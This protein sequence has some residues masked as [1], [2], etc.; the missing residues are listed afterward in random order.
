MLLENAK[1][2]MFQGFFC[3]SADASYWFSVRQNR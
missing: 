2:I 3:Q 1:F